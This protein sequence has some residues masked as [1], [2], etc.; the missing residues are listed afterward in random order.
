MKNL[1][2]PILI[3]SIVLSSCMSSQKITG[4]FFN[5]EELPKEPFKSIL[6][7]SITPESNVRYSIEEEFARVLTS[8]GRKV[9]KSTDVFI[10]RFKD[11]NDVNKKIMI[12][13]VKA[14]GCDAVLVFAVLDVKTEKSFQPGGYQYTYAPMGYNYYGSYFGYYSHYT[15][16]VYSPGYYSEDKTYFLETN[17]YNV[18]TEKLIWSIKSEAYNPKDVA[19]WFDGYST[20]INKR[21]KKEGLIK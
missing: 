21:L 17:M 20:L 18:K 16:Q 2:F 6:I 19:T 3:F 11:S 5:R 1:I 15:T 8:H 10:P 14:S 12:D 13:A 9:K 4:S 7:L